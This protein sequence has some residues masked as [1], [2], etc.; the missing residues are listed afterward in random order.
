[1]SPVSLTQG[2]Y[3]PGQSSTSQIP[4]TLELHAT[5]STAEI[6]QLALLR[7]QALEAKYEPYRVENK[8]KSAFGRALRVVRRKSVAEKGPERGA[9]GF[10]LDVLARALEEAASEGNVPLAAYLLELGADVNFSSVKH[11]TE[12][13]ALLRA[14]SNGQ[15]QMVDY[16]ISKGAEGS[17]L[18]DA[19]HYACHFQ[20]A[21]LATELVQVYHVSIYGIGKLFETSEAG[22][23]ATTSCFSAVVA[24][25]NQKDRLRLL[26]CIM[27]QDYF[28]VNKVVHSTF[29]PNLKVRLDYTALA[30]FV[31]CCC[32]EGVRTLLEAGAKV[33][34]QRMGSYGLDFP[35]WTESH[36]IQPYSIDAISCLQI[37]NWKTHPADSLEILKLLIRHNPRINI[38]EVSTGQYGDTPLGRAV[39]GGS[40]D[41]VEFL[42]TL[43][44]D[45]ETQV[46][47]E[48][49]PRLYSVLGYATL[50]GRLDIVQILVTAGAFKWGIAYEG[51][52]ALYIAC[53][54]GHVDLVEYFL[55]T[56]DQLCFLD[57]CL[58]VAVEKYHCRVVE[59]LLHNGVEVKPEMWVQLMSCKPGAQQRNDFLQ[60]IDLLLKMPSEI[61]DMAVIAAIESGNYAG[62]AMVLSRRQGELDFPSD[63][64]IWDK[65]WHKFTCVSYAK[66][67]HREDF[68]NLLKQYKWREGMAPV[69][70]DEYLRLK[71][72]H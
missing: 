18:T 3:G 63:K 46:H 62:L 20:H 5:N 10:S 1:M 23:F 43:G 69:T 58:K 8:R 13:E 41:G 26:E 71:E 66:H 12:H 15:I 38:K 49:G 51:R 68:E 64:L 48:H 21:D 67:K 60:L 6:V 4:G 39:A 40:L 45:P 34:G 32:V 16:L 31:G 25:S 61:T 50:L 59:L 36:K 44:A 9:S 33:D 37:S 65:N 30:L 7:L 57:D 53:E 22:C 19:V 11:R 56:L 27:S 72:G 35:A 42:L 55:A 47:G 14:A 54:E 24:I 70:R 2:E 28:E 52:P 29:H 17:N